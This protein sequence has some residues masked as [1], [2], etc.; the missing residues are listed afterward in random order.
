VGPR[1]NLLLDNP[2]G[3]RPGYLNLDP[4]APDDDPAGRVKCDP[5]NLDPV[6]DAGEAAELVAHDL[7][8]RVPLA[9]ANTLLDHWLSKLAHGGTIT[10]S[11]VD[12]LEVAK[13]LQNRLITVE[14]AS[15]LLH[16]EQGKNWQFRQ[17]NYTLAQIADTLRGKGLKV[18]QKRINEFRAIVVAQRP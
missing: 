18:Q 13:S 14:E 6:V 4:L 17:A 12:L 8:D 3:V 10:V 9:Q 5:G 7:L 1:L 15:T 2:A 16:G 11:C